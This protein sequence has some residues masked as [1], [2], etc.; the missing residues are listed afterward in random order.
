[1]R[2][3]GRG[4]WAGLHPANC[5]S[6]GLE[7]L[8]FGP[9]MAPVSFP[10]KLR[11][12]GRALAR[13]K[14]DARAFLALREILRKLPSSTRSLHRFGHRLKKAARK[15]RPGQLSHVY[16]RGLKSRL[17]VAVFVRLFRSAGKLISR[18]LESGCLRQGKKAEV[19]RKGQRR[20]AM[21]QWELANVGAPA[22][23][24]CSKN[25]TVSWQAAGPRAGR[26]V[27]RR[28]PASC[29]S[30]CRGGETDIPRQIHDRTGLLKIPTLCAAPRLPMAE[31]R[32]SSSDAVPGRAAFAT[33]CRGRAGSEA[34]NR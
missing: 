2:R 23:A 19:A 14:T 25:G 32:V 3:A 11:P 16:S 4:I 34:H 7:L 24:R 15:I 13:R 29:A 12:G 9:D 18:G 27:G 10:D 5:E 6:M 1:M 33:R 17:A 28:K 22:S 30:G 26:A 21:Y 20:R 8:H 31:W